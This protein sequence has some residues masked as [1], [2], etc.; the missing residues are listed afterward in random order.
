MH[1]LGLCGKHYQQVRLIR[2]TPRRPI[3]AVLFWTKVDVYFNGDGCW[4]WEGRL[5]HN[6]YGRYYQDG[7]SFA[8]HRIAYELLV[9][10]IPEGLVLDHLCRV[11][12]CVRPDH[13]EPVTQ[14]ENVLRGDTF[15]ARN[16]AK[17]H[18]PKGHP[19]DEANTKVDKRGRRSCKECHRERNRS[20][21]RRARKH[22]HA[23]A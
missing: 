9:G 5:S 21:K 1:A 19:Y 10:P 20:R 12:A 23:V 2:G 18:C 17:T 15:Q 16:A 7:R 13:L 11:P 3:N 22:L 8:A 14:R 6:G 4:R